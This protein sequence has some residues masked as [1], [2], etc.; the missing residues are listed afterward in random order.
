MNTAISNH[1][2]PLWRSRG[3]DSLHPLQKNDQEKLLFST[4]GNFS[5][6][7]S[8]NLH[9]QNFARRAFGG[10]FKWPTTNFAIRREALAGHACVNRR[11]KRLAAERALD[12]REFFHAPNLTARG[13]SAMV[14]RRWN[15]FK[16]A[17]IKLSIKTTLVSVPNLT[18][19]TK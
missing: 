2:K 8:R 7:I 6:L 10:N 5:F 9:A 16:S 17:F 19:D 15:N 12:G 4:S 1:S 14:Q 11:R 13:Q 18:S 3:F